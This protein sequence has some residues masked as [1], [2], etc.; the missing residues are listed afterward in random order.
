MRS[1]VNIFF[2]FAAI[3]AAA[4]DSDVWLFK[5]R[6]MT[7]DAMKLKAFYEDCAAKASEP[8]EN[9]AVPIENHPNGSV[10]S[11]VFAKKAQFFLESGLVWGE[12]VIVRE[13]KDDG[14]VVAQINAENCVVDRNAKAGW[15]QGRVKA[16]YDGT[17]LEGEGVYLDFKKEF[18]IIT[19]KAKIV[20]KGF[21]VSGRGKG[22]K[23]KNAKGV[24]E[25]TSLTSR[26]ADYDR[27]EGVVMFEDGVYLDNPEYKFAAEQLFVFLQGTNELKRVVAIGN[28][29]VTNGSN[30]GV[31]DR[32]VYN[33]AKGRVTM[34][35][36]AGGEAARLEELG[37]KGVKN[38]LE[39]EKISFWMDSEQVE[40]ENSRITVDSGGKLKL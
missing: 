18:V 19:D 4:F 24:K 37:K 15:A 36:K 35:G 16:L 8:A 20:S 38:R 12:G 31:C 33:R 21:D 28:V 13:L 1:F 34:Y 7:A 25:A 27:A 17:V 39:G 29:A 14:T 5:R 22:A 26:R 2:M 23:G 6:Q 9:V 3:T 40:V 11:S 30:C 32:A 10:K